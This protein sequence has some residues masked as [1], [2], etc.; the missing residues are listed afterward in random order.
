MLYCAQI[1]RKDRHFLPRDAQ[2]TNDVLDI[3]VLLEVTNNGKLKT[4]EEKN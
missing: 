2:G 3:Y 4:P 1:C